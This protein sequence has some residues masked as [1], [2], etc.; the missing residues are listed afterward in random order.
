MAKDEIVSFSPDDPGMES[1][2]REARATI[3]QF[4]DAFCAP[5]GLQRSFLLKAAFPDGDGHEHIWM[6]D[7][8]FREGEFP[9]VVANEPKIPN[10]KFMQKAKFNV[11]QVTDWMYIEDGC[12][13]GGYTTRLIRDRMEPEEKRRYDSTAPYKFR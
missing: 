9:G 1:A 8:Q 2:I 5:S 4:I 6:A 11:S 3:K 13:V 12:L 7:L 10:L